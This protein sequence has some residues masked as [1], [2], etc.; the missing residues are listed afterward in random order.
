MSNVQL[1]KTGLKMSEL[2]G[3]RSIMKDIKETNETDTP[4]DYVN[5]SAGN[6]LVL[7][8][9]EAL[10]RKY[11]HE[12]LE[13]QE[14][15][16]IIGRYG[17]S[18]G[19]EPF[20]DAIVHWFNVEY[21]WN[22]TK[23]NVLVTPGSQSL[24]FMAANAFSG[25]DEEGNQ[26]SLVLPLC[27]DYTGYGG[28]VLSKDVLKT[29]KP[30]LDIQEKHRFKYRPDI[31]K[32]KIDKSVGAVLFSRPCNPSGN[33][34]TEQEVDRIVA[35]CAEQDVPVIID[36]AY[37]PPFP[38]MVFTDMTPVWGEN[39][40][41][42][43]SLSKVG[44]PGE[45]IGVAI[46]SEKYIQLLEAFQSNM[47]IHSSRFGQALAARA[48][49]TGELAE[50]STNVIKTFYH[51]RFLIWESA[52]DRLMPDEV[53]WH[54]HVGEGSIFAWMW[55]KDLPISDAELYVELKQE[56]MIVVP[57]S[58]FF[59]GLNEPWSH[60]KECIRI[61]LTASEEE[62]ERGVAILAKVIARVYQQAGITTR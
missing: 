53:P 61:S 52:L 49:M 30:T 14:F 39:V 29:Y 46:A 31:D 9:V 18:Q 23:H 55:F 8:E 19:Y 12:L 11:A 25:P 35:M 50:V 54:L 32:L 16:E 38:D 21:G 5:V 7:P 51:K 45:R 17:S 24:Y 26:R 33:L 37:A 22:L 13:G 20:I 27:P 48:I 40:I 42:C 10:W 62:L 47:N 2:T 41:H 57:G 44:L 59:S 15:G 43:V 56:G 28:V 60:I 34:M 58:T 1:S 3:V 4:R 6:P 36:S